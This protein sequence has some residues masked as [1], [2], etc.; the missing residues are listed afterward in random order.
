MPDPNWVSFNG[1]N[2]DLPELLICT[3]YLGSGRCHF[4]LSLEKEC[5]I[6]LSSN[7]PSRYLIASCNAD[8]DTQA[9]LAYFHEFIESY[10][11][12]P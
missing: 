12:D 6:V 11:F 10:S 3:S 7:A 1:K 9:L 5:L 2:G 4:A 8:M